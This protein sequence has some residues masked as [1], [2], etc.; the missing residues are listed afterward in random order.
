MVHL[1][2]SGFGRSTTVG[3]Y[4]IA[5]VL[6]TCPSFCGWL[7]SMSTTQHCF[8]LVVASFH[9]HLALGLLVGWITSDVL[10]LR[11]IHRT[12]SMRALRFMPV[13]L[14]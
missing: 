5:T 4:G 9:V 7:P 3:L 6:S 11:E 2:A 12:G 14:E 1:V 10:L 8:P 13:T